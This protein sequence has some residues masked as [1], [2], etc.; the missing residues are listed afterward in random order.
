[1]Q[2]HVVRAAIVVPL[3][4]AIALLGGAW[5]GS[6]IAL[7]GLVSLAIQWRFR[8]SRPID[9]VLLADVDEVMKLE[10][11]DPAAADQLLERALADADRREEQELADLRRRAISDPQ[12]AFELRNRLRAKLKTGH[13][14]RRKA[15]KWAL[16]SPSGAA[17][18]KEMDLVATDTQRQLA[19]AEQ[20]V[21]AAGA[22]PFYRRWRN[23]QP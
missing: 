7:F 20:L 11:S 18:L 8:D 14:A 10:K 16:D 15:E 17:V 1:M 9:P 13:A 21:T 4:I 23:S 2:K 5:T 12:V 22:Y 19:Q 3:G 6:A